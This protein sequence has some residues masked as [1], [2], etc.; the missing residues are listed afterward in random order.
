MVVDDGSPYSIT[1]SDS[2]KYKEFIKAFEPGSHE[3][4]AHDISDA[5]VNIAKPLYI[6]QIS[7]LSESIAACCKPL[8]LHHL[9]FPEFILFSRVFERSFIFSQ[10]FFIV[11]FVQHV[12]SSSDAAAAD[13]QVPDR[14]L[15]VSAPSFAPLHV[16]M[17]FVATQPDHLSLPP[18]H[19]SLG[20]E[21]CHRAVPSRLWTKK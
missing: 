18:L 4:Y 12:E 14:P 2:V 17:L 6:V 1:I 19:T 3:S 7:P 15:S 21:R 11:T 13:M 5:G 16:L 9:R 20:T 10:L 8:M